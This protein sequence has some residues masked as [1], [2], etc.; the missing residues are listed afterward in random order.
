M[1]TMLLYMM[2]FSHTLIQDIK[3]HDKNIYTATKFV[4]Y[5]SVAMQERL[6]SSGL[7]SLSLC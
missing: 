5:N 6:L 2:L 4:K 1:F 3:D 7:V